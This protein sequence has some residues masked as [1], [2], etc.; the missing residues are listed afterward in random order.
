MAQVRIDI[1]YFNPTF[2]GKWDE[3]STYTPLHTVC[4]N[5]C[6][7][8]AKSE[9]TGAPPDYMT[10]ASSTYAVGDKWSGNVMWM[11]P[12][13]DDMSNSYTNFMTVLPFQ[14]HLY[15]CTY[16]SANKSDYYYWNYQQG[17]TKFFKN[18]TK[19]Y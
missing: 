16:Y 3:T 4:F 8:M 15:Y 14:G 18:L 17:Y 9:S 7:Y 1:G 12:V 10:T 13:R 11:H 2:D 5:N 19:G 6:V